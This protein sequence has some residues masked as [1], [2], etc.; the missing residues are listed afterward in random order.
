MLVRIEYTEV[1][2]SVAEVEIDE[3]EVREYLAGNTGTGELPD[4][5]FITTD[6]LRDYLDAT[7]DYLDYGMET[8]NEAA[9]IQTIK[10]IDKEN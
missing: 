2:S 3:A 1:I 9:E 5:H 8:D 10:I 7:R 4:D 6:D